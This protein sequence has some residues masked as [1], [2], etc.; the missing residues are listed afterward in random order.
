MEPGR[1]L[2]L[3]TRLVW[4]SKG[5]LVASH[6]TP[7]LDSCPWDS[8]ALAFRAKPFL[9]QG[10]LDVRCQTFCEEIFEEHRKR[11]SMIKTG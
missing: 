3:P 2:A 7:S 11:L 9:P 10:N 1:P 5:V 8:P 4:G 6:P